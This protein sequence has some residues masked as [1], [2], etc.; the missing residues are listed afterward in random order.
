[1][2]ITIYNPSVYNANGERLPT[3]YKADNGKVLTVVNGEWEPAYPQS[4]PTAPVTVDGLPEVSANDDGKFLRVVNGEYA[5]VSLTDVS[6][7]GA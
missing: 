5:L 7:G 2:A 4:D 6:K 1:M 3:V